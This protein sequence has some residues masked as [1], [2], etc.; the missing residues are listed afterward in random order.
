MEDPIP[1]LDQKRKPKLSQI[2]MV[3]IVGLVLLFLMLGLLCFFIFY[4]GGSFF[5]DGDAEDGDAFYQELK[6]FDALVLE[7]TPFEKPEILNQALD[8]LEKKNLGVESHLSILKR[9]RFLAQ[10]DSR[11]IRPYQEAAQKVAEDMPFSESLAAIAA[12]ALLLEHS[13]IPQEITAKLRDYASRLSETK[14]KPLGLSLYVLLGDMENPIKAAAIPN[15]ETLFSMTLPAAYSTAL[16]QDLAI[17][18]TILRI[19][20][21]DIPGAAAQIQS[22]IQTRGAAA[23]DVLTFGAEFFYDYDDPRRAAEI[24]SQLSDEKSLARQADAL[25]LADYIPGAQ[26]IWTALVSPKQG[27]PEDSDFSSEI[28]ARSLYNLAATTQNREEETGYLTSLLAELS[29][30]SLVKDNPPL[31]SY[32]IYG[33]IRYTRLLDTAQSVELLE[34]DRFRKT[35]LIGLELIRRQR[36]I[37]SVDRVVGETWLL[38]NRYPEDARLY[39][40]GSYLFDYQRRYNEISLLINNAEYYHIHGIWM[41]LYN[42]LQLVRDGQLEAGEQQL[43]AIAPGNVIWQI[44]ANIARILEAQRSPS[45]ALAYYETAAALVKNKEAAARI[46]FRISYCLRSLDRN[47]ESRQA[48]EKALE[49]NPDYL[50]ARL[51]LRRMDSRE[52]Y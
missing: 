3:C 7:H 21:G 26:N 45:A 10:E 48:L 9:R 44:P 38:I 8:K 11:F 15:K 24:F 17:D 47:Q 46:Q 12:E 23:P 41:D 32:Y 42:S 36:D 33:I 29:N 43:K 30:P 37:W 13:S 28:Q 27:T 39:Q 19:F 49:F 34:K 52:G 22:M 40:W 31:T 6:D 5:A 14:L 2:Q 51:E 16:A 20:E 25:W 4:S 35:P 18:L 50:S 1:I